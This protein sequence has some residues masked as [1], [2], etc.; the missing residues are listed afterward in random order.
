VTSQLQRTH[1]LARAFKRLDRAQAA[2]DAAKAEFDHTFMPW[3]AGRR[4]D[5]DVAREQLVSTGFLEQRK[6][7]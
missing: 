1:R 7:K 5:R 2:Y 3:A 4:I 6:V